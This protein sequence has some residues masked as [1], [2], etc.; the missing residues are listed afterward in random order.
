MKSI[1]QYTV[2]EF[3]EVSEDNKLWQN[4]IWTKAYR[5]EA[6]KLLL[7]EALKDIMDSEH[8]DD[9]RHYAETVIAEV[10]NGNNP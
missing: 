3:A 1:H 4:S 7:I 5:L 6:E 9:A 8:I 2:A 10:R